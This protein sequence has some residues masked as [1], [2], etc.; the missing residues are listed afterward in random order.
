MNT[1]QQN[2][3][4]QELL[5]L[6]PPTA[7]R[8]G[9]TAQSLDQSLYSAF[10]Q[11]NVSVIYTQLNQYYVVMEVAP[12]Y[13]QDP[14]GLNSIYLKTSRASGPG[15]NTVSPL[16]TTTTAQTTT[17]PLQVNHTGL[18]PSVTVSFNLA[19]GFAL[20]DATREISQMEA[21]PGHA[22]HR[23]RLLCRHRPGL[24]AVAVHLRST[25]SLPPCSPSSSSS[26]SSMRAWSTPSPSSPPCPRPPSA[27]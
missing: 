15:I 21:E 11:S 5:H 17:T 23:P 8:L 9:Q 12:P 20:S 2:G 18:F 13:W 3:G 25:S 14:S 1:D 19:N 7:A 27:P 6:R 24:P 4:L 10:G 16:F 22:R 26:A